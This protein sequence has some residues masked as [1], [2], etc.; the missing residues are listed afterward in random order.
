[1]D[2]AHKAGWN[3]IISHRSGETDDVTIAHLA[4]GLGVSEIKTGSISRG[5]R[6]AKYDELL[7]IEEMLQN[8]ASFA[9]GKMFAK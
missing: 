3:A 5:E 7:R 1:V 6:I 2:M 4:V 8:R 9:G